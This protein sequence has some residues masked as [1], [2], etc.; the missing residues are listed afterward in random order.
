M[1]SCFFDSSH[2]SLHLSPVLCFSSVT[3]SVVC[4]LTSVLPRLLAGASVISSPDWCL[5]AMLLLGDIAVWNYTHAFTVLVLFKLFNLVSMSTQNIGFQLH[6]EYVLHVNC[7]HIFR[8]K[9]HKSALK[10]DLKSERYTRKDQR[11]L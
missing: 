9:Y 2:T 7:N 10:S 6:V 11:C 1:A 4:E 8:L 5:C 3:P